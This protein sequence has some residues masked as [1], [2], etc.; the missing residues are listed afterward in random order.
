MKFFKTLRRVDRYKIER[1]KEPSGYKKYI[2]VHEMQT[3]KGINYQRVFK[4]TLEECFKEKR[5]LEER[6]ET[7]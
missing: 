5:I 3:A 4:G 7:L 6:L 2:I 1:S